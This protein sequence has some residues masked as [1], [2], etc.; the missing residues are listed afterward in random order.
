[1]IAR[2]GLLI[3]LVVSLL[4]L[5]L[6]LITINNAEGELEIVSI[7]HYNSKIDNQINISVENEFEKE[8]PYSLRIDIFSDDLQNNISLD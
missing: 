7:E 2:S 1:M 5:G 6:A 4:V 8:I 3:Q